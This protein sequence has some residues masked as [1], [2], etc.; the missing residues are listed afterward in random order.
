VRIS[1]TAERAVVAMVELAAASR[2]P[3]KVSELGVDGGR[4]PTLTRQVLSQLRRA[5]LVG[6]RRGQHGGY[7]L[8]M[9]A[10][11][12]TLAS[13]IEVIDGPLTLVRGQSPA[14]ALY[15]EP[16]ESL[17]DVW[18]ALQGSVV[19]VLGQVTLADVVTSRLPDAV[20]DLAAAQEH[21]A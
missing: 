17:T 9:P 2:R 19:G 18:L 16:A 6:S 20:G 15:L 1:G 4:S 7:W 8:A 14:L 12:I 21:T 13:I 3:M 11:E 10:T 5:G